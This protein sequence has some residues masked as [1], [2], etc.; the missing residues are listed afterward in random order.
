MLIKNADDLFGYSELDGYLTDCNGYPLAYDEVLLIKEIA[1]RHFKQ[2]Y[3]K[4]QSY[5][6]TVREIQRKCIPSAS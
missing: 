6:A 5:E 3:A 4:V 2:S 1:I